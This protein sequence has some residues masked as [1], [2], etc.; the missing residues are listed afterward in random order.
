MGD[1]FSRPAPQQA[2]P[3]DLAGLRNLLLQAITGNA[4]AG[5]PHGEE[6]TR[7]NAELQR[8]AA[9]PQ[10][11]DVIRRIG[12]VRERLNDIGEA[13]PNLGGAGGQMGGVLGQLL[14]MTQPGGGQ[15]V[16]EPLRASSDRRLNDQIT[17][18]NASAPGRFSSANL[19][20]QGQL[21]ERSQ[22]DFNLLSAQVLERG[23]D[24][25][26][27]AILSVLGPALGPTFGGPFVQNPSGFDNLLG[28]GQVAGGFFMPGMGG[29][30]GK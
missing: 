19:F 4:S 27:Q 12:S 14:G 18:L 30:S 9:G 5:D 26:L 7:L 20:T 15:G 2:V 8:L 11:R 28:A 29:G 13:P 24:R 1:F 3:G 10:N 17:Q 21:R 22:E 25:R 23:E 6:R 16:L